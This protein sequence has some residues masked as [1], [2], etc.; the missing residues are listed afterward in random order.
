V[1]A[2]VRDDVAVARVIVGFSHV[3]YAGGPRKVH[4]QRRSGSARDGTWTGRLTVGRWQT[5][6]PRRLWVN[7]KDTIANISVVRGDGLSRR[8]MPSTLHVRSGTDRAEPTAQV[9][10][11]TPGPIDVTT[12]PGTLTVVARARDAGSGVR[13][14]TG[15]LNGPGGTTAEVR[16]RRISG[17]RHDGRWRG[18]VTLRP[19]QTPPGRWEMFLTAADLPSNS[20]TARPR[21]RFDVTGLDVT[22][23]TATLPSPVSRLGPLVMTFDEDVRGVTAATATMHLSAEMENSGS[24]SPSGALPGTW[25]CTS[26]TSGPVSCEAGPLRQ[27]TFTPTSPFTANAAYWL[28]LNPEHELALTDLSGN[29]YNGFALDFYPMP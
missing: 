15:T 12:Q 14:V 7:M 11:I 6:G 22:P 21:P 16:L 20:G 24:N 29:P 8:G 26:A 18:T 1:V 10:S 13:T 17:D 19:C 2:H 28:V 4:L 23:P 5:T 3:P 25:A 9:L 27:A